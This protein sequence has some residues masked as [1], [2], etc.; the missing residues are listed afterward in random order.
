MRWLPTTCSI[1]PTWPD[2]SSTLVTLRPM[3]WAHRHWLLGL[4]ILLAC[5]TSSQA[6]RAGYRVD[7]QPPAKAEATGLSFPLDPPSPTK[8]VAVPAFDKLRFDRP[9]Y[10]T[11]APDGTDRL[12]VVEQSGRVLSFE[13]RDDVEKADVFLDIR[14]RVRTQHNEEGLLGLAFPPDYERSG[15]FYV[16]Y[17]ASKP[18]RSQ[19]SRFRVNSDRTAADPDSEESILR[20]EQ[21]YGNHNGGMITFGPDGHLYIGFGDGGAAGDP[22]DAGQDLSVLLGK[23]LRVEVDA[24]GGYVVP[25]GNPF[26]D[27][28]GARPEIWAYGLRNPWRFS[29]DRQTGELWTGDVGQDAIEEIDRIDVGKNYG[30]RLK[31]GTANYTSSRGKATELVDPIVEYGH[32]VGQSVTGGY[33]YRGTHLPAFRGAYFYGDFVTG[34]VWALT[35]N[36]DKVVSNEAVANVPMLA[37]FGEDADGELY[38]VSLEGRIYRF[39]LADAKASAPAFPMVLSQTGLFTDT[40]SLEPSSALLPYD[41]AWPFWSDGAKKRRWLVLPEDGKATYTDAGPWSFPVGT[42]LVKHFELPLD[43]RTDDTVRLET[44]VMVHERRGWAGYSYRWNE[45]QTDATLTTAP[46]TANFDVT[47]GG[48]ASTQRW[49]FPAGS[50]CLRCHS[51]TN[52]PILGVRTSQLAIGG[53]SGLLAKWS[54]AGVLENPPADPTNIS[55]HPRFDDT[56]V[57]AQTRARTYLDVNCAICHHRG[58]PAP[59]GMD[60]RAVVAAKDLNAIDVEPEDALGLPAERRIKPGDHAASSLWARMH[61]LERERMPPLATSVRDEAGLAVLAAW[62]DGLAPSP[63]QGP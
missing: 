24:T 1:S 28:A 47:R 22:K 34:I 55:G 23:I 21:P 20:L 10:L 50:D 32:D 58:G 2:V 26:E 53:S 44:R 12:F 30:W 45:A 35:T 46:A 9:L 54:A 29:F 48:V 4:G 61:T 19:L 40:A 16:D 60:F 37:S 49:Y 43:D 13:N 8:L 3:P 27:Q 63:S 39:E 59:G 51:A 18:R 25:P 42:V 36:G 33:V 15:V 41:L 14:K 38:A 6:E 57:D 52:G 7:P 62:I 31:E 11:A 17:S 5:K 56:T